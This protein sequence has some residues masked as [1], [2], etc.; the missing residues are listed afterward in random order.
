RHEVP[1]QRPRQRDEPRPADGARADLQRALHESGLGYRARSLVFTECSCR[2][3]RGQGRPGS[4]LFIRAPLI[5]PAAPTF[6]TQRACA[7]P[8]ASHN[9][10][11]MNETAALVELLACPRCDQRLA[12]QGDALRCAGCRID[13]PMVAS[14][15]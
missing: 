1:D 6:V 8:S 12:T 9:V 11:R 13:F 7:T 4:R 3:L 2:R 10:A 5:A 15:P 14:I